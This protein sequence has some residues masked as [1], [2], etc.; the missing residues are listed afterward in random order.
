M[1]RWF[2]GDVQ[3]QIPWTAMKLNSGRSSRAQNSAKLSSDKV[4]FVPAA[5]ASS[6]AK[7]AWSGL[8]SF[9]HHPRAGSLAALRLSETP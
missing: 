9:P 4:A 3:L 5:D 8:T 6:R 7:R 1:T 2:A